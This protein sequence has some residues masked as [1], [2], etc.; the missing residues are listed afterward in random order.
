MKRI[1]C[2]ALTL[3]ATGCTDR[4]NV[5]LDAV[6]VNGQVILDDGTF[7]QVFDKHS[8]CEYETIVSIVDDE[9]EASA[10][11]A[12]PSGHG[13]LLTLHATLDEGTSVE[14]EQPAR[15]CAC[16]LLDDRSD[17][18]WCNPDEERHCV[19]LAATLTGSYEEEECDGTQCLVQ[20]DAS[21]ILPEGGD[22]FGELAF[23]HEEEWT[24]EPVRGHM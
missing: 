13:I 10:L 24:T 22:F 14:R 4:V 8:A 20:L 9:L 23:V 5:L 2:L 1:A 12:R 11:I 17:A 15:L 6:T 21:F 16:H 3:F 7:T 18:F 19:D